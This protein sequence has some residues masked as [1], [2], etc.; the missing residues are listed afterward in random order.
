MHT[1]TRDLLETLL[2]RNSVT[3]DKTDCL[4]IIDELLSQHEFVCEHVVF[5]EVD[6]L[7]AVHN[8]DRV[9]LPLLAL[10]GHTDV[11]P[12]GDAWASDPFTPT[13]RD[14]HLFARGAADMKTGVVTM[15]QAALRFIN[16]YPDYPG[17]IA[18]MLTADEE[19][20]AVDGIRKLMPHLSGQGIEID[21]ALF[22]EPT[23]VA[24]LGDM[25]KHGRRGSL[26]GD[27][28]VIGVQGH[29]AYPHKAANP[30]HAL[31]S[32]VAE[33]TSQTWCDGN[34]SFPATT[35]QFS[36]F[37]AGVG[38]TNVIPPDATVKFNFRYSNEVNAQKLEK[39]VKRIVERTLAEHSSEAL[40][41]DYQLD[42]VNSADPFLTPKGEVVN[43]M[44][45]ACKEVLDITPELSTSGGTSDARF[46]APYGVQVIEFGV[47]NETIHQ[48]DECVKVDDIARVEDTYLRF[49]EHL[50]KLA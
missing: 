21:Y 43:A 26:H 40:F 41:F 25:V 42:W 33:L 1:T 15:I 20:P 18:I 7:W 29:V 11:V 31:A 32:V 23:S 36:G 27:L 6:N 45:R 9:D 46:V 5:G 48:V 49:Y 16:R 4:S 50:F 8:A 28:K 35:L 22:T 38:A 47:I 14:G 30:I 19:G 44:V 39:R 34:K 10:G 3:P 13:E 12:T 2:S 24:T 17:R 37:Q